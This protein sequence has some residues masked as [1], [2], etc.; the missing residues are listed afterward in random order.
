MRTILKVEN[1][2]KV[3]DDGVTAVDHISFEVHEGEI[4]GLIGPNGAG[5]TTT[6]HMILGLLE[7]TEGRVEI[8]GKDLARNRGQIL[9]KTNFAAPYAA[10]PHNLTP[11]ENLTVF[12]FLYGVRRMRREKI[13]NLLRDFNLVKFRSIRTG[14]LSSGE[15][16]RLALAKAFLSDPRF[17]LLDEPTSSLDPA[18][19]QDIRID[20]HKRIAALNG[21]V[22]WTSH[23]MWEIET[24]CDRVILLFHG[25]IVADDTPENLRKRFQKQDLE[26][27]FISLVRESEQAHH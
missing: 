3:Y 16:M 1:L 8:F 25:K 19:A 11:Y 18:I 21:A 24:I 2:T 27:L 12:S 6:I 4:V 22:L 23:N 13:E 14:F 26:E 5:K 15:Q 10:L 20:I 9:Q 17:L 7:P